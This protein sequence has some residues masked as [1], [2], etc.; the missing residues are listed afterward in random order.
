MRITDASYGIYVHIPFCLRKCLYCDFCSYADLTQEVKSAYLDALCREIS[1]APL[2]PTGTAVSAF[3]GGGT[4]SLLSAEDFD[5][6]FSQIVKKYPFEKD[7]EITIEAN[8]A[9]ASR[10]KLADLRLLGVNRLSVGVQSLADTELKTLGRVHSAAEALGFIDDARAVGFDNLN[11]DLMY[12]I[13]GQT[14]ATLNET[15]D[16]ICDVAPEHISA[17]GLILEEGTT[18]FRDR[19]RYSF[20]DEDTEADMYAT[21]TKKLASAAYHHYE[22]S[23]YAAKGKECIHNLGYWQSRPYLGFGVSAFSAYD[24]RRYGNTR[25]LAAYIADPINAVSEV[26][27]LSPENAEYDYVMLALR[28]ANGIC[29]ADFNRRFGHGFFANKSELLNKYIQAEL[30]KHENGRTY[31]TEKGFYLSDA[32][33]CEIL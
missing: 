24:N 15:L 10:K 20:I 17:Y 30:L 18:F 5:R 16:R 7:A 33:L 12:A 25:D 13:P 2:P 32:V 27:P 31:L 11:I 14:V 19:K 8:P 4:P 21:V 1:A 28:T 23:N 22:I 9:S 6:I 26:E 3:F 29:E